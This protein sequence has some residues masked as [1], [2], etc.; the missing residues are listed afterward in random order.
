MNPKKNPLL[1]GTLLLTAAG[2]ISRGIGFLYRSFLSHSFGEASMGLIQLMSPVIMIAFSLTGAG[3]Q[4]AISRYTAS[5]MVRKGKNPRPYLIAGSALCLLLSAL[6]SFV[7]Y[8]QA[9]YISAFFLKEI[10]LA[11]LLRIL[12]LSFPMTALHCC[13]NGYFYGKKEARIPAFTQLLEQLVRTGCVVL[14]FLFLKSRGE[15]PDIRL[16]AWGMVLGELASCLLSVTAY[17]RLTGADRQPA[18]DILLSLPRALRELLGMAVPL[19]ASRLI[20]NV[21][22]S[23]EAMSIPQSLRAYGY[24]DHTALSIYGVLMGMAF[25]L[26]LFPSALTNSASVLLM[27]MVSEAATGSGLKAIKHTIRRCLGASLSLGIVCGIGFF[28][29]ADWAGLFLF[30]SRLAGTFIRQLS[31]L[32][33]FLY[34]HST[35]LSIIHGLKKTGASLVINVISQCIRLFFCLYVIPKT[36]ISGFFLGFLCS[37]GFSALCCLTLIRRNLRD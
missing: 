3:M 6:Y 1:T 4:T 36:G 8:L 32:C 9:D 21:L 20:I 17:Q 22:Q 7:I 13:F 11:P 16:A 24:S 14:L 10:R 30:D 34:L 27:P 33:P 19:S 25:S 12:S 23:A 28:F 18:T 5:C 31:F 37:E 29:L 15:E 35:L 26:I 2:L